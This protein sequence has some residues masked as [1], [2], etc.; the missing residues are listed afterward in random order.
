MASEIQGLPEAHRETKDGAGVGLARDSG[1]GEVYQSAEVG[2][3]V[4]FDAKF[5]IAGVMADGPHDSRL[6]AP[7]VVNC[8][9]RLIPVVD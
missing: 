8:R 4:A 1:L 3:T 6:P 5:S 7:E 9:S 2:T